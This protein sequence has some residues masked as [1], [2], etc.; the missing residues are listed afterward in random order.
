M[1]QVIEKEKR[2]QGLRLQPTAKYDRSGRWP[3]S[4]TEPGACPRKPQMPPLTVAELICTWTLAVG[5]LGYR[6]G[7]RIVLATRG[8]SLTPREVR[9]I[10]DRLTGGDAL[11]LEEPH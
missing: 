1:G 2:R 10:E 8:R 3:A 7:Y 9:E 6:R 5:G 11:P 4:S